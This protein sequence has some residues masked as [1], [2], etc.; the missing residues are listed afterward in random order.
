MKKTLLDFKLEGFYTIY[1]VS[2]KLYREYGIR[3]STQAIRKY[4]DYNKFFK[5]ERADNR[6]RIYSGKL[7][8]KIIEIRLLRML[9]YSCIEI[10][11]VLEAEE[12]KDREESQKVLGQVII[13]IMNYREGLIKFTRAHGW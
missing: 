12:G 10:K 2:Q 1:E 8:E 13:D 6:Y 5:A 7:I 4:E 11:R 3:L 9:D